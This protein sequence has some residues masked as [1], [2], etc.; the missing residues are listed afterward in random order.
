MLER[1][2]R[3]SRPAGA[4]RPQLITALIFAHAITYKHWPNLANSNTQAF[5]YQTLSDELGGPGGRG[6]RGSLRRLTLED[7]GLWVEP[8]P[9]SLTL[10]RARSPRR[11]LRME[12]WALIRERQRPA[13]LVLRNPS[14]S[15]H[16]KT[17]SRTKSRHS[18]SVTY[19]PVCMTFFY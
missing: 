17:G 18:G 10:V 6:L 2:F 16:S 9:G 19:E 1:Q 5:R 15:R 14:L 13:R 3:S 4:Q 7:P 12:L 11:R 8:G